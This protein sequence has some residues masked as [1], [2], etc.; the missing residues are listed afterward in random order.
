MGLVTAIANPERASSTPV[1]LSLKSLLKTMVMLTG[2]TKIRK[3]LY[4]SFRELRQW[5]KKQE[6]SL[7]FLSG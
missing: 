5:K 3:L 2:L 4:V 6:S 1:N 7:N